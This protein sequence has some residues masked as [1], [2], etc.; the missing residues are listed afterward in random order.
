MRVVGILFLILFVPESF[1]GQSEQAASIVSLVKRYFDKTRQQSWMENLKDANLLQIFTTKNIPKQSVQRNLIALASV[2]TIMFGAF[3]GAMNVM[4]LYS[5][6]RLLH[7]SSTVK[8]HN[9]GG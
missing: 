8:A 4:L 5:E 3:M 1:P 2:N 6:V 7:K 9:D